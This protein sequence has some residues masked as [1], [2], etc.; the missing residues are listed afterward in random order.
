MSGPS[1]DNGLYY[2]MSRMPEL[3]LFGKK[4][5]SSFLVGHSLRPPRRVMQH[6]LASPTSHYFCLFNKKTEK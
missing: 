2:V 6:I 5:K 4:Q 1:L 3:V